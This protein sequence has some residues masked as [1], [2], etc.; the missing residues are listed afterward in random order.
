SLEAVSGNTLELAADASLFIG[1]VDPCVGGAERMR[2]RSGEDDVDL[3]FMISG[4]KTGDE[5]TLAK[6]LTDSSLWTNNN[7]VTV[8]WSS[9]GSPV[10]LATAKV[11]F[12]DVPS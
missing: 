5:I 12:V 10:K 11:T 7:D 4:V 1:P 8:S 2:I 3:R 9:A 6:D